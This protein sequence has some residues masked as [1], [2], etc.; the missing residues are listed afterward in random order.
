VR[1]ILVPL[2]ALTVILL[3]PGGAAQAKPK[4]LAPLGQT[5]G[6]GDRSGPAVSSPLVVNAFVAADFNNDGFRDLAIGI[7]GEDL[8]AGQVDAGAVEVLYGGP[9]RL[10]DAGNQF[11]SQNSKGVFDKGEPGDNFGS[12]VAAGDINGDGFADLAIGVPGEDVGDGTGTIV[13]DTGAVNLLLGSASGLVSGGNQVLT[14][15]SQGQT[16]TA[17][18]AYGSTVMFLDFTPVTDKYAELAV[19]VPF[20][21]VDTMADAGEVFVDQGSDSG[22]VAASGA[23]LSGDQ[24]GALFGFSLIAGDF[25]GDIH[26]D[27]G[28]GEPG[29]RVGAE[30]EAGK[31]LIYPGGGGGGILGLTQSSL[32][33]SDPS[34]GGDQFGATL[35]SGD[36]NLDGF[37]DLAIGAPFEDLEGTPTVVD[38]GEVDIVFGSGSG[39][40]PATAKKRTD[41][42]AAD[43][44]E[45]GD[46]FGASLIRADFNG[47]DFADLAVGVPEENVGTIEDAGAVAVL[48]GRSSG[49]N[50]VKLVLT[51]NS[52]GIAG[53]CEAGDQ[54]GTA[55]TRGDYDN[56]GFSDLAV[57]SPQEDVG[58]LADAGA[59]NAIYGSSAGLVSTG[60]RYWT[61]DTGTLLDQAEAG[62]QFG[63]A[64]A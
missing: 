48:P 24:T 42:G 38:A 44:A 5:T 43:G 58:S 26:T 54:F 45:D 50:I 20:H 2:L 56:D 3:A 64:L 40:A 23:I 4:K 9:N 63:F 17:D 36:F 47:D 28:V 11:W 34:E 55:L 37:Q 21:D 27:L 49:I 13:S 31:V 10:S 59:V 1:R 29:Y 19:G 39:L 61:Q 46:R 35:A 12:A 22:P 62:D 8:P 52:P 16:L 14:E 18:D 57:G 15:A 30:V 51:Q 32:A 41:G 60:N 53:A 25:D 6:G 7:P 33:V